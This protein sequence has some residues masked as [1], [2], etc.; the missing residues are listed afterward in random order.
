MDA[1]RFEQME[2]LVYD[3][4]FR[5]MS[6]TPDKKIVGDLKLEKTTRKRIYADERRQHL[7]LTTAEPYLF[8]EVG[9][10]AAKRYAR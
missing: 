9:R 2:E 7:R 3:F 4:K 6:E 1:T 8:L 5:W 10:S